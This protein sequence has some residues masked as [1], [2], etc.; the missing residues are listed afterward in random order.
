MTFKVLQVLNS[1]PGEDTIVKGNSSLLTVQNIVIGV[2][3]LAG[4]TVLGVFALAAFVLDA[5][6]DFLR[7]PS[8][9]RSESSNQPKVPTDKFALRFVK[10]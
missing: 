4:I 9:P 5:E 7:N 3:V 1:A 2:Y 8:D 6:G 10:P